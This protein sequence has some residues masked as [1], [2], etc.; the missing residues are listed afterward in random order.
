MKTMRAILVLGVVVAATLFLTPTAQATGGLKVAIVSAS[1]DTTGCTVV[2]QADWH[3]KKGQRVVHFAVQPND[4]VTLAVDQEET[5][6][7]VSS[8]LTET[9]FVP[10]NGNQMALVASA[11]VRTLTGEELA[12]GETRTAVGCF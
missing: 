8:T 10:G 12:A 3:P 2:V 11:Q 7:P 1:G 6:T 9:I 5:I 4:G